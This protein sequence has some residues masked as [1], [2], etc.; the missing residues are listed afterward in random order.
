MSG[1]SVA[2]SIDASGRTPLHIAAQRGDVELASILIDD[3]EADVNAQDSDPSSVLDLAVANNT[4]TDFV[5]LLLDRQVRESGLRERNKVKFKEMKGS[6]HF[7]KKM[8]SQ[9]QRTGSH[10]TQSIGGTT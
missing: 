9:K 7:S 8:A 3:F 4:H 1:A 10:S 2:K 6:I 5:A